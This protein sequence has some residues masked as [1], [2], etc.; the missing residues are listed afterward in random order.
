MGMYLDEVFEGK[1]IFLRSAKEEDAEF[2]VRIRTDDKKNHFVHAVDSDVNKERNW[3]CNQHKRE[4]DYFF[5]FVR[6]RDGQI[7]GNIS[8]YNIKNGAGELGRWLSYGSAVENLESA[9]LAHDFAFNTLQISSVYTRTM[10]D[11]KKVVSFWRRFGGVARENVP[12]EDFTVYYNT[13]Y[14][15]QYKDEI[16]PKLVKMLGE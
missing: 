7:L 16:R 13:V 14:K 6:K 15:E 1:Y 11:N 3:I 12:V 4:G 2:I 10:S 8:I 5:S 9:V